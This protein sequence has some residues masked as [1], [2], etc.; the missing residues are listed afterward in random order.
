DNGSQK[1]FITKRLAEQLNLPHEK[2]E[3][4]SISTF[5]QRSP[6]VVE[7]PVVTME[8]LLKNGE[9]FPM[10]LNVMPSLTGP[11]RR[12]TLSPEDREV[13]RKFPTQL[14]AEPVTNQSLEFK[15]D[16]LIGQNY[17]WELIN[18][19][20]KQRLPSGLFLIPSKLGLLLGG[21]G[22]ETNGH[23]HSHVVL[24]SEEN[25]EAQ[26]EKF[27]SLESIGIKDDP[28]MR[29]D[30]I[31][32]AKFN[33]SVQF[34]NERYEVQWPW[35]DD[36]LE[37]PDN[38][39]LAMGRF[40]SLIS[41][42]QK[43]PDLLEKYDAVIQ[44]QKAKG[45]IEVAPSQPE[46]KLF[47]LPHHAVI[48]PGRTTKV[49]VV[50]D[51]SAKSS[52]KVNSLNDCLYR[53]P[54]ILPDLVGLL[55][56]FRLEKIGIIADIEKAFLQ[57]GLQKQER[58]ATRFFWLKNVQ[59]PASPDN[60][61][62]LRF[63]R[64]AF[65][66]ISSPFLLAATILYHLQ[67]MN[68]PTAN[69]VLKN[70]Y[71][72]NV[73][74]G[75]T[76]VEEGIQLYQDLKQCFQAASM[77][78]REWQS[79]SQE[80]LQ[81]LPAADVVNKPLTKV[82]GLEWNTKDDTLSLMHLRAD[83]YEESIIAPTKR[84]ILQCIAT[85]FDPMG[86][87]APCLLLGKNFLRKLW[88]E[89]LTWDEEIQSSE[90]KAEWLKIC[91]TLTQL[92]SL[93]QQRFVGSLHNLS[94]NQ[95]VGFVDASGLA[96]A[97][98]IYLRMV[99]NNEVYI[100]LLFAKTRLAPENMTIPRLELMGL[101]IGARAI[102]FLTQQLPIQF[103][104]AVLFCDSECV[105]QWLKS[106]KP[107]SVF[108]RNRLKEIKDQ[109]K[110]SFSYVHTKENP[111]DLASRG[112]DY[113]ELQTSSLWWEGPP[114]LKR[115]QSKW[116]KFESQI[117]PEIL[118]QVESETKG[119]L[120]EL[121]ANTTMVNHASAT[122]E[123]EPLIDVNRFSNLNR[124]LR[125]MSYV[126]RYIKVKVWDKLSHNTQQKLEPKL[127]HLMNGHVTKGQPDAKSLSIAKLALLR[128]EQR[129]FLKT[130]IMELPKP[131]HGSRAHHLQIFQDKD[132]V[133]QCEG[134]IEKAEMSY[135]TKFPK[136]LPEKSNLT[137]LVC[138]SIHKTTQH[139]GVQQTLAAL[140]Q[141]FWLPKGRQYLQRWLK[142]CVV[143]QRSNSGPYKLPKMPPL[144]EERVV[145]S[146][147]FE[148]V[149]LDYCGPL[150]VKFGKENRKTWICLITCL[151]TRAVHLE[152]VTDMSSEHFL[153]AI[154]RFIARR[155]KPRLVLSDNAKQFEFT[156]AV[157]DRVWKKVTTHDDVI[158]YCA[159][160]AIQWQFITALSPWKGGVYERMVGI[161]KSAL[162]KSLG[163]RLITYEDLV[164]LLCE[165]E[166]V[167]NS[168]P[169]TFVGSD[170]QSSMPLRPID[171]LSP[172]G[173]L[174]TP[175]LQQNGSKD[176]DEYFPKVDTKDKFLKLYT[177]SQSRLQEFWHVWSQEYLTSLRER[178][179]IDHPSARNATERSPMEGAIVLLKEALPR[180]NWKMA[181][182]ERLLAGQDGLIR[183][184]EITTSNGKK[185]KRPL[186][187]LCPLEIGEMDEN[188]NATVGS[189]SPTDDSFPPS[190]TPVDQT[191]RPV[192]RS[193]TRSQMAAYVQSTAFTG[194]YKFLLF[195]FCLALLPICIQGRQ[196][197]SDFT[198]KPIWS[199]NCTSQGLVIFKGQDDL[200]C[201]RNIKCDSG[202]LNGEG[203]C[204]K[205]CTCP[206]WADK[207]SYVEQQP[208]GI[209]DAA[210]ILA[211]AKYRVCLFEPSPR[212][213]PIPTR[214]DIAQLLLFNGTFVYVKNLNIQWQEYA[215]QSYTCVG[216]G[217]V[218]GTSAFCATHQCS[219][220]GTR[221]CYYPYMAAAFFINE[222][223]KLPVKAYGRVNKLIYGSKGQM[224]RPVNCLTCNIQCAKGGI[225]LRL[226]PN[227]TFVDIEVPPLHFKLSFPSLA[228][229][230]PLPA[231]VT[232][233]QHEVVAKI[234]S[235]GRIIREIGITCPAN[236]FCEQIQCY[237]CMVRIKNLHC[238]STIAI[239]MIALA[240][241]FV[242]ITAYVLLKLVI[243][244]SVILK[245]FLRTL[246]QLGRCC[247][248]IC[249]RFRNKTYRAAILPVMAT[250]AEEEDEEPSGSVQQ[251]QA[252][253]PR[254]NKIRFWVQN[255]P[256]KVR[257]K[258]PYF[259]ALCGIICF[260]PASQ[261]CSKTTT[262]TAEINSCSMEQDE[263]IQCSWNSVARL[264]LVP[265]GQRSCLLLESPAKE[266][267]GTLEIVMESVS[268]Q[269]QKKSEYFTRS[270]EMDHEIIKRCPNMGSCH[271]SK[272]KFV[273]PYSPIEEF[274]KQANVAP[275]I[276][277]CVESC[278]G[279]SC[280]CFIGGNAC[281]FY[282]V[283]AKQIK[284]NATYEVFSCPAWHYRVQLLLYL[285]TNN[286]I[287]NKTMHLNVGGPGQWDDMTFSLTSISSP[288]LPL[289]SSK[290]L[291]DYHRTT[292]VEASAAGQAIPNT[293]GN[294][295]CESKEAADNFR[296]NVAPHTCYCD[297]SNNGEDVNC[298]CINSDLTAVMGN[299]E[300]LLPL[301]SHGVTIYPKKHGIVEAELETTTTLE[302]Q[303]TLENMA[304]TG[305]SAYKSL[306]EISPV[307]VTGCYSCLTGARFVY[308]CN[309]DFGNTLA[310]VQ[311]G[312]HIYF[313]SSCNENTLI[314]A[315]T[316]AMT[317]RAVDLV[318]QVLCPGGHTN[319]IL[320]GTLVYLESHPYF[321]VQSLSRESNPSEDEFN[322]DWS[323]GGIWN[324]VTNLP[325]LLVE[326]AVATYQF[327]RD[328]VKDK[329]LWVLCMAVGITLVVCIAL[330]LTFR[331]LRS[332]P[333]PVGVAL[334][335]TKRKGA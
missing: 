165:T 117:T 166:A 41:R 4:L 300:R 157:L 189:N 123:D 279:W 120:I 62:I 98:V 17:F 113:S 187:L 183:S 39:P 135:D 110:L 248:V 19:E 207:C 205:N 154:H 230:L 260:L 100:K 141:E 103:E 2:V 163:K 83:K 115:E 261:A 253:A 296:C 245:A 129:S 188:Q 328:W 256:Q 299:Q 60:V 184:A 206:K 276:T 3:V 249:K 305:Q 14:L 251:Q 34:E 290:F 258:L 228:L 96:Y 176:D 72:D 308:T 331:L 226:A 178:Y 69:N 92:P 94:T 304:I 47:Y 242:S 210:A 159:Q 119:G 38:Y 192:T 268:L 86:L 90:L 85:L 136:L 257:R 55:L 9:K 32:L 302:L 89:K 239:F 152:V 326:V 190:S 213:H 194:W 23:V 155:G 225:I 263:S 164:T 179:K 143:C 211:Q 281:T 204:D 237:F 116:P 208:T 30:D 291:T 301:K 232:I 214:V 91:S 255:P 264:I 142:R 334:R 180:A 67:R 262:L 335:L 66:V 306:C 61:I 203:I 146:R 127:G 134:Q 182:I 289:L 93:T 78:L 285:N 234:L 298:K 109:E 197:P 68:T 37:M 333:T 70:I 250:L 229:R 82:M 139:S 63:T 131:S 199:A 330:T 5:N 36:Q 124:L 332:I 283:F 215:S 254:R 219:E 50:Y 105:L 53:G 269:C 195:V 216:A 15:P 101:L 235:N 191:R 201:W 74:I 244:V 49:R 295:Q 121:S 122:S 33:A 271:D 150:I 314:Y 297:T 167:V 1:S 44:D 137:K 243:L 327:V 329:L 186:R 277:T 158:N 140:R 310:H 128:Q 282:R 324:F 97:C 26:L 114:W 325:A 322:F 148:C 8:L 107:L 64:V 28:K 222:A 160:E 227:V 315:T 29:D 288:T 170:I 224:M 156:N 10:T 316:L 193:Q 81:Q 320:K 265:K 7:S 287:I 223:G 311:C 323:I 293:V 209:G 274:S 233:Q 286:G 24:S 309:T 307:N 80:L 71:V 294:F 313:S 266:P 212:C 57:I 118:R 273:H 95:L 133:L 218:T 198:G 238:S 312:E 21:Q 200:L 318:C 45:V 172:Q 217:S 169:I 270:F 259:V 149:G 284:D 42:L 77:N 138:E 181:K 147:P 106:C 56:R 31:A 231:D 108:V 112:A 27:W 88:K 241:Y 99:H 11:M 54:V 43:D 25:V 130:E 12:A 321:T 275:G 220:R 79:N 168:R 59:M 87:T 202:H 174:G 246:F 125:S 40:K 252:E 20:S 292:V 51:A 22:C 221:F 111:A 278:G 46:G 196:C 185:L 240:L 73:L 144:P 175:V 303:I 52:Q 145:K 236:P 153:H 18:N 84:K 267:L 76:T 272:C 35:K 173:Q 104:P 280:G 162:K 65:G 48:T 171:F 13:L 58:D 247:W 177:Q 75:S 319:F 6:Q 102:K 126:L 161:C 317:T 132:R 151:T 16:V